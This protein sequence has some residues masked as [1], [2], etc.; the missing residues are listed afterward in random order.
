[1]IPALFPASSS[2]DSPGDITTSRQPPSQEGGGTASAATVTI[3][4]GD[5]E[6][7]K[8]RIQ[9]EMDAGFLGEGRTDE[10]VI[11]LETE[12]C[13]KFST[14]NYVCDGIK[15]AWYRA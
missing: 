6:D 3:T 8:V 11:Q 2:D 5:Q 15:I 9:A 14:Q 1:M 10:E 4:L 13:Q 12:T 7:T